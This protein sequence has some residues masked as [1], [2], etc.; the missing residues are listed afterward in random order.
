VTD[1]H[2]LSVKR[3]RGIGDRRTDVL[4]LVGI[5]TIADLLGFLP[6][7]YLDRSTETPLAMLPLDREVTGVGEVVASRL[8]PGRRPRFIA[9]LQDESGKLDCVWFAG[10]KYVKDAFQIGDWVSIG[11]KVIA[12][13]GQR[14]IV[15]PEVEVLSGPDDED[16][17]IHT[18][19]IVP[20]YRT[21]AKMK[22]TYLT[23]R[24]LRHLIRGALDELEIDDLLDPAWRLDLVGLREAYLGVHFPD[25]L[26]DVEAGRRRLAFEELLTIRVWGLTQRPHGDPIRVTESG[27]RAQ[28]L[29]ASL[30]FDLTGAQKRSLDEIREEMGTGRALHRLLQ[31]DVGSG[32]TLVALLAGLSVVDAGAQ[33]AI[34]VPTEVLAEQHA[35]TIR[36]YVEP[37]GLRAGLMTGRFQKAEREAASG[38]IASGQTQIVVGTHALLE[39]DVQFKRLG[40]VVVDEQHRFGVAQ[41]TQ[42]RKK[43]KDA[44]LLVMTAT[45]IPRSLALTLYGHLEVSTIDELPLGRKPIRTGLRFTKDREKAL[46]FVRDEVACGRQAYLVYPTVE[47]SKAS[48]V[49]SAKAAYEELKEGSL[50]RLEIGLIYGSMRSQDKSATMEAFRSGEIDVLVSTT[51]IEVGVDVP[52]ASVMMI[53]HAERF[54]L[55]QLHQ[56]RGRVGRGEAESFCILVADPENDLTDEA[57]ARLQAMCETNDGFRISEVDLEI[58]GSGQMFGTRQAGLPEFRYANL[59][60]DRDLIERART[61]GDLV[62]KQDP[63]L[64]GHVWLRERIAMLS[65]SGLQIAEAG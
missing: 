36:R 31:G 12:F 58:R 10:Y 1:I 41:R 44:H 16:E 5:H 28:I 46:G 65:E 61:T 52:N 45:P 60:Q 40:M 24:T 11:G 34:M 23:A 47:G 63:S 64:V 25:S 51:V 59:T 17:R 22:A 4:K 7:R 8:V 3:V 35:N 39:E 53:E 20:L 55:S 56:L 14:Q 57:T 18:G 27:E 62:W 48:Q 37:L 2:K 50:R 9:T 43:G 21:T 42:L 6:Y 38:L 33:V 26:A 19:G 29:E 15:H 30:P 13:S 54:G 32:K 49:K